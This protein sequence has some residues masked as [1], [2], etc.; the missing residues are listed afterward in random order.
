MAVVPSD[1]ATPTTSNGQH[2]SPSYIFNK[3]YIYGLPICAHESKEYWE[4]RAELKRRFPSRTKLYLESSFGR[5]VLSYSSEDDRNYDAMKNIGDD[6]VK[7][8]VKTQLKTIKT[9][10]VHGH[11]D[12]LS[13]KAVLKL[14]DQPWV[15][16]ALRAADVSIYF[17]EGTQK[18]YERVSKLRKITVD[19]VSY[20]VSVQDESDAVP[21]AVSPATTPAPWASASSSPVI[22]KI[23]EETAAERVNPI[24]PVEATSIVPIAE[25][26][27][28]AAEDCRMP[29]PGLTSSPHPPPGI[30]TSSQH[31]ETTS[32][33]TSTTMTVVSAAASDVS[34]ATTTLELKD[35]AAHALKLK[36]EEI[37]QLKLKLKSEE[38]ENRGKKEELKLKD[39]EIARLV[40][41]LDECSS[42]LVSAR[43]E[44]QTAAEQLRAA[45]NAVDAERAAK[46]KFEGET[47]VYKSMIK[48]L[49][50][51]A[52]AASNEARQLRTKYHKQTNILVTRSMLENLEIVRLEKCSEKGTSA[53]GNSRGSGADKS[54]AANSSNRR[55]RD[56]DKG[57]GA[58]GTIRCTC[59]NCND[60]FE[61]MLAAIKERFSVVDKFDSLTLRQQISWS[62]SNFS[63]VAHPLTRETIDVNAF[64]SQRRLAIFGA[65][66]VLDWPHEA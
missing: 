1:P 14:S 24:I 32:I 21:E 30:V 10:V 45:T 65:A 56:T 7:Y 64:E 33:S 19:D 12:I 16:L 52:D 31:V 60:L 49:R 44:M 6:D 9:V 66:T 51:E 46:H 28:P 38:R 23:K 63:E 61:R 34:S 17:N 50:V 36:D 27:A 18:E 13:V 40:K 37:A 29:P 20:R 57:A 3:L 39:D 35:A 48:E 15:T 41:M 11:V 42:E 55:D 5:A 53:N 54:A 62:Y 8:N 2:R 4:Q 47:T 22:A 59:S 43:K 25:A 58:N 26:V